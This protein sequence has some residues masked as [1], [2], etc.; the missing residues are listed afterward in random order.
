MKF[1]Y[2]DMVQAWRPVNTGL[3]NRI[4]DRLEALVT[5]FLGVWS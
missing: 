4:V 5:S 2:D 3:L 1:M